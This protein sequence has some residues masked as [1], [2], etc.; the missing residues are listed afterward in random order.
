MD[1]FIFLLLEFKIIKK[2]VV[3]FINV[4]L[5]LIYEFIL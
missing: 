5:S 2:L 3:T 4:D 1:K